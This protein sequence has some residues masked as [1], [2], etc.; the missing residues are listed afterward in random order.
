[1]ALPA[2]GWLV[3]RLGSRVMTAA[4]GIGLCLALPLPVVSSSVAL[5]SLSLAILGACNGLLDVSMNAQAA[6][7]E[8]RV[9]RSVMSSF[10]ALFSLGGFAGALAAGRAMASGIGGAAHVGI[11]TVVA[12]SAVALA[13]PGLVSTPVVD[14]PAGPV[15]ARP[16][17]TLVALG[18]LALLGLMAGGAMADWG[19]VYLHDV[20]RASSAGA[21]GGVAALFLARAGGRLGGGGPG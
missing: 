8:R 10:H 16:S 9:G 14:D 1:L 20:L 11:A 5:L 15:V 19:A 13:R 2:A 21:A 17:G 4:A 7:V 18:I 12:L 3:G 6:E